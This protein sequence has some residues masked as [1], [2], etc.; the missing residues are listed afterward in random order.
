MSVLRRREIPMALYIIVMVFLIFSNYTGI[1]KNVAADVRSWG[2][3]IATFAAL[4]G[5]IN[6]SYLHIMKLYRRSK[7]WP[8][9]IVMFTCFIVYFIVAYI[10]EPGYNWIISNLSIPLGA[11][12]LSGFNTLGVIF[13]GSRARSIWSVLILFSVVATALLM[14]SLGPL[15]SPTLLD[16]ATWIKDYPTTG[17][18]RAVTIGIGIGLLMLVVRAILGLEKSYLGEM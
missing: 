13:R 18:F 7:G 14:V 8:Y 11:A 3:A 4:I 15:I 9:S 2:I 12:F 6:I 10:Y 17:V 16:L 5:V 1:A